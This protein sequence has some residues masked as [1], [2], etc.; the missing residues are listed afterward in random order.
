M[1]TLCRLFFVVLCVAVGLASSQ[2]PRPLLDGSDAA[3]F[4]RVLEDDDG[5]IVLNLPPRFMWGWGPGLHGYCG[6][7]STQTSALFFGSWISQEFVRYAGGNAEILIGVNLASA[8]ASLG[9]AW[10][11]FGDKSDDTDVDSFLSW[12]A[13]HLRVGH[14][15]ISGWY[16]RLPPGA[17]D[18]DYDHIVPLVGLKQN[19]SGD[20]SEVFF[21]DLWENETR[22]KHTPLSSSRKHWRLPANS[23]TAAQPYEYSLPSDPCFGVAVLGRLPL[24][25]TYYPLRYPDRLQ[26]YP[27]IRDPVTNGT[28]DD[29]RLVLLVA[30]QWSE[31]DYGSEDG[32]NAQPTPISFQVAI[33]NL[34]IGRMYLL[35]RIDGN[36][37]MALS[38]AANTTTLQISWMSAPFQAPSSAVTFSGDAASSLP[39][40]S[41]R[42]VYHFVCLELAWVLPPAAA[43]T[44]FSATSATPTSTQSPS[45]TA[46]STSTL[47]S[48]T[49][50]PVAVAPSPS[51]TLQVA[52][53]FA[54][55]GF[56]LFILLGGVCCNATIRKR[57]RAETSALDS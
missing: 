11:R 40:V 42:G 21:N 20:V 18:D 22:T 57:H 17:G 23:T 37:T 10:E 29:K 43:S 28:Q 50:P 5:G 34:T 53:G 1:R 46:T 27:V 14:P 47:N 4:Q 16:E 32:V 41:S 39:H 56:V 33:F 24:E 35:V 15:V 36:R 55:V 12:S 49:S 52:F 38:T 6:S 9:F 48:T 3:A 51:E 7:C 8:L 25:A 13:T 45:A 26:G 54:G 30:S 19:S 2:Q 31:P 44:Y